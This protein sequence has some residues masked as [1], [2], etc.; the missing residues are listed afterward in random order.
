MGDPT[1]W[2]DA[3]CARSCR[4]RTTL[5]GD[6]P[7]GPR[8]QD[9]WLASMAKAGSPHSRLRRPC[10]PRRTLPNNT[11]R[12]RLFQFATERRRARRRAWPWNLRS[13][14]TTKPGLAWRMG[15]RW[16]PLG[17]AGNVWASSQG[18]RSADQGD[19]QTCRVSTPPTD[20][21]LSS[22]LL[23]ASRARQLVQHLRREAQKC[24][25]VK[26]QTAN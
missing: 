24:A 13:A 7:P 18:M 22:A 3:A 1:G 10:G 15:P 5:S 12:G 26:R 6:H 8:A 20:G 16:T 4:A 19:R 14:Q 25:W 17:A 23:P 11:A 21:A 2:V 9:D